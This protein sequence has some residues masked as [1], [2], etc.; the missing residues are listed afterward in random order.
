MKPTARRLIATWIVGTIVGTG[1]VAITS[2]LF[3]RSYAPLAADPARGVW[4]LPE[5]HTYRWRSE[6][7]ADT[8]IGPLG[9]PG[10]TSIGPRN[11]GVIRVALWGD[12]QAEGVCVADHD[13]I[14]DQAE[15]I[16]G[17]RL[18]VFPL[19]RSGEDAADW[20][21]QIPRVEQELAIDVHVLLIVDLPDLY[22][23]VD[24]PV[25]PP[26][27]SDVAQANA[28]IAATM[29]A[30][31]IQAA[32][33]LLREADETTRRKLRFSVG[34]IPKSA[35]ADR[36]MDVERVDWT[37]PIT[38]LADATNRPVILLYAPKSPQIVSGTVV[39]EDP[40]AA[41]FADLQVIANTA[42]LRVMDARPELLQSFLQG[43]WPHGFQNGHIGS[44]H[45]NKIGN[46]IT[47]SH[48]VAATEDSIEQGN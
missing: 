27:Q 15:Q 22:T 32:R 28:A 5:G 25:P 30:F 39:R 29:P 1:L 17:G 31:V 19:A 37:A 40:S 41:D 23:A 13:K 45:L 35:A 21:T 43:R 47:A 20:L 16:S 7:Y 24:A 18:E 4:T 36:K 11:Q 34:P 46:Q 2:P 10:K 6:G 33:H 44:G 9:M 3:V 26:S 14:F 42:G 12:S 48:L 8:K 38:A